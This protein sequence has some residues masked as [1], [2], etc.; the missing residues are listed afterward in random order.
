MSQTCQRRLRIIDG[1]LQGELLRRICLHWTLFFL[2]SVAL[3]M[4]LNLLTGDPAKPM[5]NQLVDIVALNFWPFLT[6]LALLP[7]FLVDT[8]R[9]SSKF[10]G[11]IVR[12]RRAM[13]GL[14]NEGNT[15]PLVF[16]DGDFW[17]STAEAY[18]SL[19]ERHTQL[20]E[21]IEDLEGQLAQQQVAECQATVEMYARSSK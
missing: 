14:V 11:P 19:V 6:L 13:E 17:R 21:R 15:K 16:R 1:R 2:L 5:A 4:S 7:F 8:I 12:L 3:T 10:S 18:N 20:L 9:L